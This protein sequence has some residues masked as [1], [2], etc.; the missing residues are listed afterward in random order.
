M[1][2]TTMLTALTLSIRYVLKTR[3]VWGMELNGSGVA[4]C[5]S[6]SCVV[7]M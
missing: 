6:G 5:S 1:V 4:L 2:A 3:G 7:E